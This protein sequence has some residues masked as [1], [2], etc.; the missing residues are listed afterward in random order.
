MATR[1]YWTGYLRLFE[2]WG[3]PP[4]FILTSLDIDPDANIPHHGIG[5]ALIKAL[6]LLVGGGQ[7]YERVDAPVL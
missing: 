2:K 4:K 7:G 6:G 5:H 1:P 3:V